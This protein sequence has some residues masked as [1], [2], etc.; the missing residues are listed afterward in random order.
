MDWFSGI[1]DSAE[2]AWDSV[3]EAG[4]EYVSGAW[5]G[6][7]NEY[8][9]P[10]QTSRENVAALP[11]AQDSSQI[12]QGQT[13]TKPPATPGGINWTAVGV[14]VSVIGLLITLGRR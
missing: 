3:T 2:S 1:V 14:G 6:L 11:G 13:A 12:G 5:D 4:T 8:L 9:N 10:D 7:K